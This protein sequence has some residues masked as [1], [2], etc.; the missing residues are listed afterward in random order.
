MS[1]QRSF[2]QRH[3]VRSDRRRVLRFELLDARR[4]LASISGQVFEDIDD[5]FHR[6]GEEGGL[7]N[8][9][10]YLDHDRNGLLGVGE[11]VRLSDD[12]GHFSFEDLTSGHY[13][14]RLFNGTDSQ[15]QNT[16]FRAEEVP[17]VIPVSDPFTYG[18]RGLTE[19]LGE[20]SLFSYS[21]AGT[22]LT[23]VNLQTLTSRQLQ[24]PG[25]IADAQVLGEGRVLVILTPDS[26][27]A[28]SEVVTAMLVQFDTGVMEPLTSGSLA[29]VPRWGDVAVSSQGHGLLVPA[30]APGVSVPLH[31][32]SFQS[33][34]TGWTT[35]A[36][37]LNVDSSAKLWGDG[38][39]VLLVSQPSGDG[40]QLALWSTVTASL[41]AGGEGVIAG[42]QSILAFDDASS[43]VV[44]QGIDGEIRVLDAANGFATLHEIENWRGPVALDGHRELL[45]GM[46]NEWTL[47]MFDLRGGVMLPSLGLKTPLGNAAGIA[48]SDSGD[49]VTIRRPGYVSQ[50]RIDNPGVHRVSL[51]SDNDT[52]EI[53]FGMRLLGDNQSPTYPTPP[54]FSILEDGVLTLHA[55]GLLS[56]V[57]NP[58]EDQHIVLPLSEPKF[59]TA[60]VRPDG[61][62]AYTP[63]ANFFGVDTFEILVS[64]GRDHTGPVTVT[65]EVLP[66]ND[67]PLSLNVTIPDFPENIIGPTK[68]GTIHID[69]V[70]GDRYLIWLSDD[71]FA[72][73]GDFIIVV[74]GA[75][76]DHE[77]EPL[78]E[79]MITARN[80]SDPLDS[81]IASALILIEDADEPPTEI[82]PDEVVIE[83]NLLGAVIAEVTLE[84]PDSTEGY[85]L[86]VDDSRFE[87]DGMTIRLRPG[88]GLDYEAES[89]WILPVS[90]R[91]SGGQILLTQ[92]ILIRVQDANDP[93]TDIVLSGDLL[94][95]R[96]SAYTVGTVAV[97]D[98]DLQQTHTFSVDD[99]R[100]EIVNRRLKLKDGVFVRRSDQ[101]E[102]LVTITAS[103]GAGSTLS[104]QFVLTVLSNEAPFHNDTRP[105]DVDGNGMTQPIDALIIINILNN[106]GPQSLGEVVPYEQGTPR[107]LD[108]NGDGRI[109][110]LDALIII[111]LLNRGDGGVSEPGDGSSTSGEGEGDPAWETPSW[112]PSASGPLS[113]S[114]PRPVLGQR[115]PSHADYFAQLALSEELRKQPGRNR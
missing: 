54:R 41:V 2:R 93:I 35:E 76:F 84:D 48:L 68:V 27:G 30:A 13:W 24:M 79:L 31:R 55:P 102:I 83:E 19:Y 111:N 66:V 32:V 81:A 3:A 71:R 90:V 25:E 95:E 29:D 115:L 20:E 87:T 21:A 70:D 11:P 100:F 16:P 91:D 22:K 33:D 26:E 88:L 69:E 50:V 89:Q 18:Q 114:G 10:V 51:W 80:P 23:E 36:T 42:L 39:Q 58:E 109:T 46:V 92:G 52:A 72:A 63:R 28:S 56:G 82:R 97:V 74:P 85:S 96:A 12:E 78:I 44:A 53:A 107:F 75:R 103:D 43:L 47:G 62:M 1:R 77:T 5:S 57:P 59:G 4:V 112:Q 86:S 17:A 15:V 98:Q 108:V 94:P 61:S 67:Q 37:T 6:S 106:S 60:I 101:A 99:N 7:A 45:F 113:V 49:R 73:D 38:G 9:V 14:V 34:W 110:P 65:I 104:K 40:I 105:S 64:D 8:R